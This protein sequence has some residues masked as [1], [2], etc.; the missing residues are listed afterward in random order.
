[1]MERRTLISGLLIAALGYPAVAQT[2][3]NTDDAR[4]ELDALLP[5]HRLIGKGRLTMW[6][7]QVY[8]ARLWALPG[9]RSDN[10]PAHPF[11]LEL[12]Y[13]RDFG[14]IDTAERSIKEM[15][16]SASINDEKANTW[17]TAMQRVI[18]DI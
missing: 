15:R 7:F 12:A 16:R 1:M 8:D 2:T 5:Q 13:L 3:P 9:F 10:L 18:P 6:G 17:M 14:S 4:L 11:A